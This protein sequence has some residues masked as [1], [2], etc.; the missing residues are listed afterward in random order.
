MLRRC[1]LSPRDVGARF[2]HVLVD[3]YQD[4]NA[5]QA[6]ILLALKPDGR[7]LTVVGDDAQAIYAFRA[8]TVRNILDFP[9]QFAPP[10]DGGEAGAELP[11]DPADPGRRQRGDRPRQRALSRK[12]LFSSRR[13]AQRPA[14]VMVRD[15][16]AQVDYVVERVL[17]QPRGGPRAEA[18]RRCCSAPRTTAPRSRSSWPG[19]TFRSSSIGGLKFLEAAHVKDLLAVLRWAENPRDQRGRL[20]RAAAAARHRPGA[21]RARLL[22]AWR[23]RAT[24]ST[25]WRAFAPPAAAAEQWP[26]FVDL[27]PALRRR[28]PLAGAGRPGAR[29]CTSRI[30]SALRRAARARGATSTSSSA[31]PRGYASR[32]RFLTDLTL[33]PPAATER[34]GR[35]AAAGR[36]LSDP[37]DD[38]LGQGPGVEG[39]VR[40]QRGRRLH[41]VRHGDRQRRARSRRSGGCS[42]SR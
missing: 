25:R 32:E 35:A 11:L 7:G 19:A 5:L 22:D 1:R 23:G 38:P 6:A 3:E 37:V 34:P 36:G 27:L 10:A 42:T 30:W 40:A 2:D 8:A 12:D 29:A 26:R 15:D 20:P 16:L 41:P 28:P 21:R 31:S 9:D 17:A 18:S 39:G 13:S 14:L 24:A 4:T 33:D